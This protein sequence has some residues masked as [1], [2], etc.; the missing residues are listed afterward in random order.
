MGSVSER[1]RPEVGVVRLIGVACV[2]M[3]SLADLC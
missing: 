1:L 3:L 2:M